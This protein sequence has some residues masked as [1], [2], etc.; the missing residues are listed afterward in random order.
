M[1]SR[2]EAAGHTAKAGRTDPDYRVIC[3]KTGKVAIHGP[4]KLKRG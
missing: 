1:A 2:L 3:A 4:D